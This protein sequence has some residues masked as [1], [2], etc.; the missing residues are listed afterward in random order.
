MVI[1]KQK[2]AQKWRRFGVSDVIRHFTNL[3]VNNGNF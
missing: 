2:W 3:D 1:N